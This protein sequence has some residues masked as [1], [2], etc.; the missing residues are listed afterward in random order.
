MHRIALTWWKQQSNL[1]WISENFRTD[2]LVRFLRND[3]LEL[4]SLNACTHN[5]LIRY[6]RSL[7]WTLFP[8]ADQS[9]QHF[10]A[11]YGASECVAFKRI[12]TLENRWNASTWDCK[13]YLSLKIAVSFRHSLERQS[14]GVKERYKKRSKSCRRAQRCDSILHTPT[15]FEHEHHIKSKCN[16]KTNDLQLYAERTQF[17]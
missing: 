3:A 6:V 2:E 17:A 8:H 14:E 10:S 15:H 7:R 13:P 4:N 1:N 11:T 5:I 9:V 16:L 12:E